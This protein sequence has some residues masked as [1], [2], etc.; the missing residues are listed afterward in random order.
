MEGGRASILGQI[1]QEVAGFSR[2]SF[3][4]LSRM[5]VVVRLEK[6][7]FCSWDLLSGGTMTQ[8]NEEL[9]PRADT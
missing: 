4:G 5:R 2:G 3:W 1:E 7:T 6:N 9:G 8:K